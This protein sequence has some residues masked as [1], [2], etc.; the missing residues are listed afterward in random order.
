MNGK[1]SFKFP[2]N[3]VFN[4]ELFNADKNETQI[5]FVY[6]ENSISEI[7]SN[8]NSQEVDIFQK[9][10]RYLEYKYAKELFYKDILQIQKII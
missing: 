7:L 3:F 1:K 6:Q 8:F 2:N 10:I 5:G 4:G 9:I